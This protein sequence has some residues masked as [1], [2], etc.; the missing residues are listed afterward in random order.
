MAVGGK[1]EAK[2]SQ[3]FL[4]PKSQ[5]SA[6]NQHNCVGHVICITSLG[7][8]TLDV[9]AQS[10]S[11]LGRL[12]ERPAVDRGQRSIGTKNASVPAALV[13]THNVPG[14][15]S[16]KPVS[17]KSHKG[18]LKEPQTSRAFHQR[19][20]VNL[21]GGC[22][23]EFPHNVL[24]LF[25][26]ECLTCR[27]LQTSAKVPTER[28]P[29]AEYALEDFASP[30]SV[31]NDRAPGTDQDCAASKPPASCASCGEPSVFSISGAFC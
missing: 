28:K 3:D 6:S 30:P 22:A 29:L 25:A 4:R 14:F 16:G 21:C 2:N 1:P 17:S 15:V 8:L 13:G 26:N 19:V 27:T 5:D 23:G 31:G 24:V 10:W 18:D 7:F 12:P 20:G 11:P 9:I